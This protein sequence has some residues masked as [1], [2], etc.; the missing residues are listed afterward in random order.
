MDYNFNYLTN[1]Y[2]N[3][4]NSYEK[5][6]IINSINNKFQKENKYSYLYDI[7][8]ILYISTFIIGTTTYIYKVFN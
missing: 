7:V 6:Y 1:L 2:N 4:E 3:N 8:P 5:E